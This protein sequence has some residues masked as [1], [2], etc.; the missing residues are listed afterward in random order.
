[1]SA[2]S[3]SPLQTV[4]EV[5]VPINLRTHFSQLRGKCHLQALQSNSFDLPK[6]LQPFH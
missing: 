4:L 3:P 5:V 2:I 6:D 1:M